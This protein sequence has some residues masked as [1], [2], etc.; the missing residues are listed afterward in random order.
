MTYIKGKKWWDAHGQRCE[1]P[2]SQISSFI[3]LLYKYIFLF[4]DESEWQISQSKYCP[5]AL[6]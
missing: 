3:V 6:R 2:W 5:W 1:L 4:V